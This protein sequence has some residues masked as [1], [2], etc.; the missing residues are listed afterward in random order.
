MGLISLDARFVHSYC[1]GMKVM[2]TVNDLDRIVKEQ[3]IGKVVVTIVDDGEWI[4][5]A[6]HQCRNI[7][8]QLLRFKCA[9]ERIDR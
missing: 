3:E 4:H 5:S 9:E 6:A 2:G 8:V 1:F 7:G